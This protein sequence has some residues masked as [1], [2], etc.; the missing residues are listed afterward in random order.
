MCL[1][2]RKTNWHSPQLKENKKRRRKRKKENLDIRTER[3]YINCSFSMYHVGYRCL[4]L[5]FISWG[6]CYDLCFACDETGVHKSEV[7]HPE[8]HN[9]RSRGRVSICL[10]RSCLSGK[11]AWDPTGSH[12]VYPKGLVGHEEWCPGKSLN[13]GYPL[14]MSELGRRNESSHINDI[15]TLS[16]PGEGRDVLCY[17]LSTSPEVLGHSFS[18]SSSLWSPTSACIV[19]SLLDYD[20][21]YMRRYRDG[22]ID[23]IFPF[24]VQT[25]LVPN[26]YL[27]NICWMNILI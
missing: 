12:R 27:V 26:T 17:E 11:K 6:K 5:I 21:C 18:A 16:T 7:T 1:E 25:S 10:L 13:P 20:L 23:L 2:P 14:W 9:R 8:A 15:R 3:I 19:S 22:N 4:I 24:N